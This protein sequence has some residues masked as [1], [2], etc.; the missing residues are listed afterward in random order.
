MNNSNPNLE[1]LETE[2]CDN[3]VID[4]LEIPLCNRS[5]NAEDKSTK[6]NEDDNGDTGKE[7]EKKPLERQEQAKEDKAKEQQWQQEQQQQQEEEEE[8]D[9]AKEKQQQQQHQEEKKEDKAKEK[10]QQQE[11]KEDKAKEQ[12]WQQEQQQQEQEVEEE[13]DKTKEEQQQ[14]QQEEEKEEE[15]K[16]KQQNNNNDDD[17]DGNV[18]LKLGT[19]GLD[20]NI[21]NKEADLDKKIENLKDKINREDN[22]YA[23][24]QQEGTQ[25]NNKNGKNENYDDENFGIA[26]LDLKIQKI[27]TSLEKKIEKLK[28][29]IENDKDNQRLILQREESKD[30]DDEDDDDEDDD[31]DNKDNSGGTHEGYRFI[32][33]K[34]DGNNDDDGNNPNDK[35]FNF[36]TAGDFSCS[37]NTEKMVANIEK[38]DPELVL[39]LG[40]LSQHS[41][42]DCWF[43]I[44]S[45]FKGKMMM[46]FGYHDVKDGILKLNQY[47]DAFGLDKLYYSFDYKRV[48]FIVMSTLSEFDVNS[49]QYKFIEKDLKAAS[50]NENTDWIVVTNYGP[51][52][53]SPSAHPAK[54]DIRNIYHPLF[55][56]YGVDLVLNGHNHNYQRTYPLTFNVD[57]TSKPTIT[58]AFTTGYNGNND[59]IVYAIVG[60]AGEGFHPLQ[61]RESYMATQFEGKFGFLNIEISNGNP[62]TNLTATFYDNK[63]SNVLDE[64]TIEKEIKNMKSEVKYINA[65]TKA[66]NVLPLKGNNTENMPQQTNGN[67]VI[68]AS[69]ILPLKNN[70]VSSSGNYK[71]LP[72][73]SE[74]NQKSKDK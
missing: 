47:K 6:D 73:Y 8:E 43:D 58:N 24:E 38:K 10:Q 39:A 34:N 15:D 31:D 74:L 59:G 17:E 66:T 45:P 68:E 54:N 23:W 19:A 13:E 56:R 29:K 3:K 46:T 37:A 40:D 50:E 11:K 26:G 18:E 71:I 35:N 36:A 44:M 65:D 67:T 12:Q 5:D 20:F 60:T 72:L 22:Q 4:S 48:H 57:K 64:F 28:D 51:F 41:T 30:R 61:G 7:E 62:H 14:Q 32:G 70:N 27:E 63:G 25:G 55:D 33:D 2:L 1:G 69:N 53:T 9:K 49:D 16:T 52:Y 21:E 42:A